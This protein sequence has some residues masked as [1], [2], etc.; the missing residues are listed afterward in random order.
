MAVNAPTASSRRSLTTTC[1]NSSAA[2]SSPSAVRSRSCDLGGVVGAAPD[3]ASAQRLARRR[4]DEDLHRVGQRS[5]DLPR[6]L[7]ARSR[8]PRARRRRCGARAPRAA[9]RSGAPSTSPARRTR[10][11]RRAG[12]L[13]VV[14]EVVVDAL[15]LP[16]ARR[17]R[18]GRDAELE[19]GHP[20]AQEPDERALADARGPGDDEDLRHGGGGD[21]RRRR[22]TCAACRRARHAADPR[23]RRS[24]WSARCGR[25]AAPCS[26]SRA[27]T[28]DRQQ[29]VEDLGGLEELRRLRSSLW[30]DTR[31]AF[32]SRLSCARRVRMTFAFLRASIRWLRLRSGAAVC[33][34][35]ELAGRRHRGGD[36]THGSRAPATSRGQIRLDLDLRSRLLHPG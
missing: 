35:G 23:G 13:R 12:E 15:A 32:R 20:L 3:Q 9:S 18:R 17:A 27:R 2:A 1:S 34:V 8:A 6:A 28:W 36:T 14:E 11:H 29:H 30:I 19:L 10:R 21:L 16:R 7:R 5:A 33:L 26:P 24:S 22:A 31:P 25:S 4:R